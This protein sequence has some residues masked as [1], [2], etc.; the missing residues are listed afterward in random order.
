MT[1][2]QRLVTRCSRVDDVERDVHHEGQYVHVAL[3]APAA[4]LVAEGAFLSQAQQQQLDVVD[5]VGVADVT[6]PGALL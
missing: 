1:S 5:G 3:T 2:A 6:H 4:A